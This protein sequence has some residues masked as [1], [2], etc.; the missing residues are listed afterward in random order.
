MQYLFTGPGL[1]WDRI[2]VKYNF[3]TVDDLIEPFIPFAVSDDPT[4][5]GTITSMTFVDSNDLNDEDNTVVRYSVII[6]K[7][8]PK[9]I[10]WC[11]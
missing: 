10:S 6:C 8:Y 11:T 2:M 9:K 5:D 1:F 7:K 4:N 3:N